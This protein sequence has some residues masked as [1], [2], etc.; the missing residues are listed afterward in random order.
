MHLHLDNLPSQFANLLLDN[1]VI[2][3]VSVSLLFCFYLLSYHPMYPTDVRMEVKNRVLVDL[4]CTP[5]DARILCFTFYLSIA[6]VPGT[7]HGICLKGT[8]FI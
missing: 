6:R 8:I 2:Y 3:V 1:C 5:V 7:S 4:V